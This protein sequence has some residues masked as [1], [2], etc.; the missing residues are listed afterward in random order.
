MTTDKL[1]ITMSERR[2]LTIVKADWPLIAKA[3]RHDGAVECQA[4]HE[5]TIRVREHRDGRRIVYGWLTSGHGGVPAGWRGSEGGFLVSPTAAFRDADDGPL[6]HVP[7]DDETVRAIRRVGGIIDDD[8]LADEC[9]ADLPAEEL[10]NEAS[11][12]AEPGMRLDVSADKLA[13]IYALLVRA[14]EYA[15]GPLQSEI[16]EA[17][18]AGAR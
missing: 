15:P 9:I 13:A 16:R 11:R 7:D 1:K 8:A 12:F 17:I 18:R 4:N 6:S 3:D 14:S 2:P 5:W 10:V